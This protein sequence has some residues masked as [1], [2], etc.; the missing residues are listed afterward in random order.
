LLVVPHVDVEAQRAL[1]L[2]EDA[3]R[4]TLAE[5]IVAMSRWNRNADQPTSPAR[6][7]QSSTGVTSSKARSSIP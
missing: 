7:P 1:G 5:V 6:S 3:A 2:H 4:D